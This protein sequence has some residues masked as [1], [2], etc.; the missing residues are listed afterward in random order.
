[1]S[2]PPGTPL[3]P[4]HIVAPLGAGG[5]GE[6]YRARDE[7]LGRDVAIKVLPA[8]VAA[9]PDRLAR[10]EREARAAAA[11]DHPN[12]LA[13][14]DVGSH[15]GQAYLVTQ[16]LEGK[17]LREG[18]ELGPLVAR[19]AAELGVQIGRGLAAAHERGIVHRDLKPSN[20]FVTND[21]VVKILDFGL[22]R[23]THLEAGASGRA[24]ASTE[25]GLTGAR[26]ILGTVGYMAPEQVRGLPVDHR[27]DIF[28]FGCVLYEMLA[29]RR[30]FAKDSAVETMGA[31]LH[32]DPPPLEG[33]G[34]Q[35]PPALVSVVQRCLE[36][37]PEDRFQSAH[38]V[39]FAI[40]ALSPGASGVPLR[41][42]SRPW[43]W[44][45][46]SA[47]AAGCVALGLLFV[48]L[49]WFVGRDA[50]PDFEPR[51]VTTRPGVES[52][53]AISP[54]G[55]EIAYCATEAGN[56][57]IWVTDIRGGRPLRLTT[58]ASAEHSPC[59][60]PDG[61]AVAFVSD[62]S[63]EAAIWKMP[64][65]GGNTVMLVANAVDPAVSWDGT[66]V[67]F[68]RPNPSGFYR[69]GFASL[70][71]PDEGRILTTD[72]DGLWNHRKPTW[73]PDGSALCYEDQRDLWLVGADGGSARRL[74]RDDARDTNAA[75]SP[76]GRYIY[77]CSSREGTL[78]VWRVSASGGVAVRVTLGTGPEQFPT[79]SR[80]GRWL[81][82]A[83][84]SCE[85]AVV[86]IDVQ[87][88]QRSRLAE[89]PLASDPRFA[90]DGSGVLFA[91]DREGG[92]DIWQVP[93]DRAAPP[94]EARRITE[95][96]GSCNHPVLS[97]DGRW[98]AYFRVI[99][100][101]RDVWV[102][103]AAGGIAA[104]FTDHPATDVQPEWS[105]DGGRLAFVS[106]RGG[107]YQVWIAGFDGGRRSG[108][109]RLLT[110]ARGGVSAPA[111]SPN[112]DD[113]AFIEWTHDG[114]EVWLTQADGKGQARQLTRGATAR[115]VV[116]PRA[117]DWL[118]VSGDWGGSEPTLRLV[119]PRTGEV[120]P[121]AES[122]KLKLS[123]S[124]P[125]FD[126]SPDGTLLAVIEEQ[127]RGDVW[128][129]EALRRSF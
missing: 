18:I 28:A 83:T 73:S 99:E 63:G 117:A 60:F 3:G 75:W 68:A 114:S 46:W 87:T 57:D 38:D 53:P 116:W 11:L 54:S 24:S 110:R 127:A 119:S 49:R 22:A 100:G 42:L 105:P 40:E 118:V 44:R 13:V 112:G 104:N 111:W 34:R 123:P 95:H 33:S 19:K 10:F 120:R 82:Y 97:P 29:G 1:M 72:A 6:V 86:L 4:Y 12:I 37:R 90:P 8:D 89:S 85:N 106:D 58:E 35:I 7:R 122:M 102:M 30:A 55:Q 107:S 36:K 27:A 20:V 113:I 26:A 78:A 93:L 56:S 91:S 16:L 48:G 88:G 50:L 76:G 59:W 31:I 98:I 84:A 5:M 74:T 80:D 71:A 64:R 43:R 66:L 23:L 65:L 96:P 70:T 15:E 47:L 52:E 121:F 77:F 115:F 126:V 32:E 103:S 129:L 41:L 94:G 101:Q 61:S 9:D 2:L 128:V 62:R 124:A 79:L 25:P 51:Q 81:S 21:G 45:R 67:A 14:Y 109:P 108:E 39:A 17:T 125:D 69:I 92:Y